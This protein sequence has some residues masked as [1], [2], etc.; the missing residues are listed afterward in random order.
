MKKLFYIVNA[1]IPTDRANGYQI[2]KMC[3]EFSNA[4]LEVE[5]IVP[6]RESRFQG[7]PFEFYNINK[8]FRFNKIR[9]FDFVK[10]HK[11]LG[12]YS[13]WLQSIAYFFKLLFKKIDKDGIIYS[14]NPEIVWLFSL[15]G[16]KTIFEVHRWAETK[17]W[18]FEY[19]IKRARKV[20]AVTN[21]LKKRCLESGFSENDV[22]IAPDAVDLKVFN[23]DISKSSAREKLKLPQDKI[24]LGYIGRFRTMGEEKGIPEILKAISLLA[25]NYANIFFLA[26]GGTRE[27]IDLYKDIAKKLGVDDKILIL[28]KV[29]RSVV[30]IYQKACDMLL[31]PFPYTKHFAYY[32]SPL[33]MFEYM[34]SKRPIIASDLPSVKDI[35]NEKNAILIKPDDY[36]DLAESVE[37]IIINKELGNSLAERAFKDV[38]EYSW[39]KRAVNILKFVNK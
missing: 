31:M 9:S 39:E 16:Y 15:R 24:I 38:Q 12:K 17:I 34:A 28:E 18:L 1:K 32:M 29:E 36:K 27:D 30:A 23:L 8:N 26:I 2:C 6:T 10:Y 11:Y 5:L 13:F 35:L 14:R 21:E 4:G 33:K 20:I 25:K 3:E 22:L 37:K 7:D 19:F